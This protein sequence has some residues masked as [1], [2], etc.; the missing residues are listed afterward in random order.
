MELK[1]SPI[2]TISNVIGS[3]TAN[4]MR[5]FEGVMPK[6]YF[7]HIYVDTRLTAVS[8]YNRN[9]GKIIKYK[10]PAISFKPKYD[11]DDLM[12]EQHEF[13][14]PSVVVSKD[15]DNGLVLES[16]FSRVKVTFDI[17]IK[18]DTTLKMYD[19]VNYL[20]NKINFTGP[21]ILSS[22]AGNT[23]YIGIPVPNII[24]DKI[25]GL[26]NWNIR[27]MANVNTVV[28]YLNTYRNNDVM[29]SRK[30]NTS[31]GK[32]NVV[33]TVASDIMAK[34][35]GKPTFNSSGTNRARIGDNLINMHLD[36]EL[37][38]PTSF[39]L[40]VSN[41]SFLI[42]K[43]KQLALFIK[44]M[45]NKDH[46][47]YDVVKI[48][49]L[50]EN[51]FINV[52]DYNVE[53][54]EHN[55]IDYDLFE[56]ISDPRYKSLFDKLTAFMNESDYSF[57]LG[58]LRKAID[59]STFNNF[60]DN[61]K[62]IINEHLSDIG[63]VDDR[64]V[65]GYLI[66]L[67]ALSV[68]NKYDDKYKRLIIFDNTERLELSDPDIYDYAI[69]RNRDYELRIERDIAISDAQN[70]N[71]LHLLSPTFSNDI[72]YIDV[73]SLE[74]SI[75]ANDPLRFRILSIGDNELD[76]VIKKVLDA[77]KNNKHV[78]KLDLKSIYSTIDMLGDDIGMIGLDTS[79]IGLPDF[80]DSGRR[81]FYHN[82]FT[83]EINTLIDTLD[84][85]N[86]IPVTKKNVINYF[87]TKGNDINEL[88]TVKLYNRTNEINIAD[89]DFNW[90]TYILSITNTIY[91][92]N[93]YIIIYYDENMFNMF[94]KMYHDEM[95][96]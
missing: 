92:M 78:D 16:Y 88:M 30:L 8:R 68:Y 5:F 26:H 10:L 37:F 20:T 11:I 45:N 63:S 90:Y 47:K 83:T 51:I 35:S 81:V 54:P 19:V 27:D 36:T 72:M 93:Y 95:D 94:E 33:L 60:M 73:T 53:H 89:F 32:T 28:N 79:F 24:V 61:V 7:E 82:A 34:F 67:D 55:D 13:I 22:Q 96:A 70:D 48:K 91:N 84:L 25:M 59:Y 86:E 1:T 17:L 46:T 75:K 39:R 29:F 50:I 87:L 40:S 52:S 74:N 3:V 6:D 15:Y 77:H 41:D 12:L 9:N 49:D 56:L 57:M 80:I 2:T 18:V 65:A 62:D 31:T 21:F 66:D 42:K 58:D 44:L 64:N 23:P 76:A 4:V 14:K 38:V 85:S 71:K 43:Y 69:D